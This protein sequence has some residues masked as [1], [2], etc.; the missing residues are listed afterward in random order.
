MWGWVLQVCKSP[1]SW[2]TGLWG[3]GRVVWASSSWGL[4]AII[5]GSVADFFKLGHGWV[6]WMVVFT[7]KLSLWWALCCQCAS[8][9]LVLGSSC[10]S[11]TP[12]LGVW[13]GHGWPGRPGVCG[14][15]WF[16]VVVAMVVWGGPGR[17]L[18]S[19]PNGT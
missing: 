14:R 10:G 9:G 8:E 7:A 16:W 18:L 12:S 11:R 1:P 3:C 2:G 4:G 5:C 6:L 19:G 13:C 17:V 15:V